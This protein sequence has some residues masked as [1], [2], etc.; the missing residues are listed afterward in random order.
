MKKLN[1]TIPVL[2]K[3][4]LQLSSMSHE[5]DIWGTNYVKED[6]YV[7]HDI[8][9]TGSSSTRNSHQHN[10][11]EKAGPRGNIYFDPQGCGRE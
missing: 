7:I 2:G 9:V 4:T 1:F 5:K 10:L 3:R 11:I 6:Q 8:T